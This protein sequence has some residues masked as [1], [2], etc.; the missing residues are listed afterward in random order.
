MNLAS[1]PT[2]L[3]DAFNGKSLMGEQIRLQ[4]E[5]TREN[6]ATVNAY[7]NITG[8]YMKLK[9]EIA[10][11]NGTD[12]MIAELAGLEPKRAELITAMKKIGFSLTEKGSNSTAAAPAVAVA[13]N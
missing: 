9:S 4:V 10:A 2:T 12:E 6:V 13:D 1:V 11:G 5:I 8:R 3:D 7:A